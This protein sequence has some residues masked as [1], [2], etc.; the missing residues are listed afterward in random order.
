MKRGTLK[1]ISLATGYSLST[2]YKVNRGANKNDLIG[3]LISL[4]KTNRQQFA[5]RIEAE[6]GITRKLYPQLTEAK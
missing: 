4:A 5:D 1:I 6:R 2:V 3:G